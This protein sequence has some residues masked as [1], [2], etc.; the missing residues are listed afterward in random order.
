MAKLYTV[1]SLYGG[2]LQLPSGAYLEP[3]G[4]PGGRDRAYPVDVPET[5]ILW[6]LANPTDGSPPEVKIVEGDVTQGEPEKPKVAAPAKPAPPPAAPAPPPV[7]PAPVET[8][9]APAPSEDPAANPEVRE[10]SSAGSSDEALEEDSLDDGDESTETH[11]E[12]PANDT[13]AGIME[14]LGKDLAPTPGAPQQLS[15]RAMRRGKNRR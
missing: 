11:A 6:K 4:T 3:A 1:I 2:H 7:P 10:G 13:Q 15:N 14:G 8:P 5:H 9:A 12:T